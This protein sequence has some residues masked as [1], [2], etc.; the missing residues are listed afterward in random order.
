MLVRIKKPRPDALLVPF[1][2]E[3][4]VSFTSRPHFTE[5]QGQVLCYSLIQET[6]KVPVRRYEMRPKPSV[7]PFPWEPRLGS[8]PDPIIKETKVRCSVRSFMQKRA[9]FLCRTLLH[10]QSRPGVLLVTLQME[11][12][13]KFLQD[14]IFK[15]TDRCCCQSTIQET[16]MV[17]CQTLLYR[18]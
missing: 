18:E 8:R 15:Q 7:V 14:P 13:V 6:S 4:K 5:N 16:S 17:L 9:R 10:R 11:I 2:R 3:T 12:E 1:P